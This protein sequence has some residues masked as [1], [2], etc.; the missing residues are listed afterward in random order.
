[1]ESQNKQ[2]KYIP[3]NLFNSHFS[4]IE[5][6]IKECA[7]NAVL[8]KNLASR[9]MSRHL[10]FPNNTEKLINLRYNKRI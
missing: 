3:Q 9:V 1:M 6:T 4:L 8:K 10:L 2:Q 5:R 7:P